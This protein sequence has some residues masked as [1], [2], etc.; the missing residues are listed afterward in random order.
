[1]RII[2]KIGSWFGCAIENRIN[3][4]SFFLL[5]PVAV[6]SYLYFFEYDK[7]FEPNALYF[8]HFSEINC[9]SFVL[10]LGYFN[11]MNYIGKT[12]LSGFFFT[13]L[14]NTVHLFVGF[15]YS[16][17]FMMYIGLVYVVLLF[18]FLWQLFQ[19]IESVFTIKEF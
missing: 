14:G 6:E 18:L 8:Q 15:E 13:L 17:Y 10:L 3:W 7:Y 16:N 11:K 4:I 2:N 5:A 1:M 19:Q 12:S 9:V